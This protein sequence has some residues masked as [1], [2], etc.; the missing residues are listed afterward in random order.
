MDSEPLGISIVITATCI[1]LLVCL[2]V[3]TAS[4]AAEWLEH[5]YLKQL[6]TPRKPNSRWWK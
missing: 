5:F 1:I 6:R 3:F 2:T 4:V